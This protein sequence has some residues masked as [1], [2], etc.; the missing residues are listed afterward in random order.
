MSQGGFVCQQPTAEC[1][2]PF[3][4]VLSSKVWKD[5]FADFLKAAGSQLASFWM[6]SPHR[7]LR[8]L[9]AIHPPNM[10][11]H[12]GKLRSLQ[13]CCV[14][15]YVLSGDAAQVEAVKPPLLM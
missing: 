8:D 12:P 11:V 15:Y 1:L 4:M 14:C 3:K 6:T 5:L 2:L 10:R 13:D 9:S 7:V